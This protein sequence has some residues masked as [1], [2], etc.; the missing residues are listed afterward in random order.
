[1]EVVGE[2][3]LR[4]DGACLDVLTIVVG[5]KDRGKSSEPGR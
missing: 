1:M 2:P 3:S 4:G 5:Q